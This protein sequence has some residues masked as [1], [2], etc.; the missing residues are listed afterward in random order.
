MQ[1]L[2][3]Y[4][5][6]CAVGAALALNQRMGS[7]GLVAPAVC[8][9]RY[10]GQ[11]ANVFVHSAGQIDAAEG[12]EDELEALRVRSLAS[13]VITVKSSL[14]ESMALYFSVFLQFS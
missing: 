3:A 10:P 1:L 7:R 13:C 5:C 6:L 8:S 14:E 9:P 12:N 2:K 11:D 4:C